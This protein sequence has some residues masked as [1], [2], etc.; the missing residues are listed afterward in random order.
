MNLPYTE[1]F[2][3]S[4][5]QIEYYVDNLYRY[6]FQGLDP[7]VCDIDMFNTTMCSFFFKGCDQAI[8]PC[9][10][11]CESIHLP[12]LQDDYFCTFLPY[13]PPGEQWCIEGKLSL[14]AS[15]NSVTFQAVTL[16]IQACIA[17]LSVFS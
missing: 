13:G 17:R 5:S 16:C 9:R 12:C 2:T 10:Q 14:C 6:Y 8:V 3:T 15:F 1:T 7:S 4:Q 11:Y